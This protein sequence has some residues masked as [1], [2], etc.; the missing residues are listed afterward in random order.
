MVNI[1]PENLRFI[2]MGSSSFWQRACLEQMSRLR[3]QFF[4]MKS[5]EPFLR[6]LASPVART[7]KIQ[8]SKL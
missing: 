3:G 4:G 1:Q 8:K 7:K 6:K 2:T 5:R